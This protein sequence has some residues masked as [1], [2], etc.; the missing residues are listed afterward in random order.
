MTSSYNQVIAVQHNSCGLQAPMPDHHI[1]YFGTRD[2]RKAASPP[3]TYKT[4][5]PRLPDQTRRSIIIFL[6]SAIAFAG[7]RPFGHA[8]AQFMMV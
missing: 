6:I 5:N 2:A 3:G 1:L 4:E 8:L 7:F